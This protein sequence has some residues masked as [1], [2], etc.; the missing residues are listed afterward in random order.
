MSFRIPSTEDISAP[1]SCIEMTKIL[2]MGQKLLFAVMEFHGMKSEDRTLIRVML[3][4]YRSE[5]FSN[6]GTV[7]GVL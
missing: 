3:S 5:M 6:E 7:S 4:T 2:E 1:K